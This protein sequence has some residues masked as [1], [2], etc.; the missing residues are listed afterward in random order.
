MQ[1]PYL[2]SGDHLRG[3]RDEGFMVDRSVAF[4][5]DLR[6]AH[7]REI[8]VFNRESIKPKGVGTRSRKG[9]RGKLRRFMLYCVQRHQR[10]E[11]KAAGVNKR[12]EG[13]GGTMKGERVEKKKK[14][15]R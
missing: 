5:S 12:G 10:G 3:A 15:E 2:I 4:H 9:R 1:L 14:E 7:L 13:G 6:T 8:D 11:K